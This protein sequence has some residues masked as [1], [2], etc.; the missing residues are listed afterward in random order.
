MHITKLS[1]LALE[2]ALLMGVPPVMDL[3]AVE[4]VSPAQIQ[5][6]CGRRAKACYQRPKI[7]LEEEPETTYQESILLHELVHHAQELLGIGGS[8]WTCKRF[9]EREVQAHHIQQE[10]LTQHGSPVHVIM[11]RWICKD[12][13]D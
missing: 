11:P 9:V 8:R 13:S 12:E 6:V 1:E 4:V 2:V 7:Y 3:P 5:Q 10:W